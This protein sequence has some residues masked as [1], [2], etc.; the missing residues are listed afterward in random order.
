MLGVTIA[1]GVCGGLISTFGYYWPFLV[2]G[3]VFSCIG[4]GLLYT[5]DEHTSSAKII[6]FQI[7][8]PASR[9][10]A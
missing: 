1:A 5:I 9:P 8:R 7:V 3:P 10:L 4:S 6:G 2:F